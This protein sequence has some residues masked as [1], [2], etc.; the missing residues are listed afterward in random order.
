MDKPIVACIQ[1]RLIIPQTLEDYSAYL[2]RFLRTAKAK[3]TALAVFPE[4][5]GIPTTLPSFSGWKNS[6][7]ISAS[8]SKH[9]K[10][11]FWQR[12]KSKVAGGAAGV[13]KADLR[14]TFNQAVRDMPESVHD[15]YVSTFAGLARQFEMTIVAGSLYDLDPNSKEMR[16]TC[17]VFGPDGSLL[18]RQSKVVLAEA[19]RQLAGRSEGWGVIPTPAGKLGILLGNDVLFPEPGRILAFQGADIL[20]SLAAVTRPATFHKI[21]QAAQSR[22]QENQLFGMISFLVGPDPLAPPEA[23]PYLGRSAIL[24][25]LEFTPR[26]S[27]IMVQIGSPMAEGAITAEFDYPALSELWEE[28]D[29]PL[30]SEMPMSQAAPILANIY[31]RALPLA[32]SGQLMLAAPAASATPPVE[33]IAMPAPEELSSDVDSEEEDVDYSIISPMFPVTPLA[34]LD[35]SDDE[36]SASEMAEAESAAP[37]SESVVAAPVEVPVE[38]ALSDD[39][40]DEM[41]VTEESVV[42]EE[43]ADVVTQ[44]EESAIDAVAE[45]AAGVTD[46]AIPA[47]PSS[48]QV[49]ATEPEKPAKRWRFP[50]QN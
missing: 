34:S 27:G 20:I 33:P 24:A 2:S 5:S 46:E 7:A 8:Q 39:A 31:Q 9:R 40:P 1:H 11:G 44:P 41:T 23:A 42:D 21:F 45:S 4:L 49:D 29:T 15:A 43:T 19:D 50:W 35:A 38:A 14:K 6:L 26:F 22:C 13:V 47:Q 48:S 28:S 10:L 18:G 12:T 36:E 37:E 17:L 3:G 30:R 16:N 25:P 32:D